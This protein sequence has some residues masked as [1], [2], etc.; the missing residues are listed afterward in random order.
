MDEP[1]SALKEYINRPSSWNLSR[2]LLYTAAL[3]LFFWCIFDGITSYVTPL[4][5]T[6]QGISTFS[7]GVIYASSSVAGA[8]FDFLL[9]KLIRSSH[10]RRLYIGMFAISLIYPLVLWQS[11]TV[12]L[13]LI[14]M[15]MWGLYYDLKN[16]GTFDFVSRH[17]LDGDHS[18]SYGILDI[19]RTLGYFVAPLIAGLV[20]KDKVNF[21][22]FG[23]AMF[24]ILV[25]ILAFLVLLKLVKK[26]A[27]MHLFR[28]HEEEQ[29][30]GRHLSALSA[31]KQIGV[32][33]LP[34]L[35][36]I[37]LTNIF[38]AFFWTIGPLLT[39]NYG[40]IQGFGSLFVGPHIYYPQCSLAGL[41]AG[42]QRNSDRKELPLSRLLPHLYY[43]PRL[44]SLNRR[45][46]Y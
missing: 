28:D 23:I 11:K 6:E 15:A 31:W 20:V 44:A 34:V 42:L 45:C 13:L 8:F 39:E 12:F 33:L 37:A 30:R 35:I 40:E 18:A 32:T 36:F 9:T 4:I 46:Y 27:K 1:H 3:M 24:A 41:W 7:M 10:F 5:I 29:H 2:Q 38:D 25:G 22:P 19:F 43:S 14:S 16:I 17:S 26:A 21:A